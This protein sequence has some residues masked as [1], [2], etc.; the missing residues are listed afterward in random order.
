MFNK[1]KPCV[2]NTPIIQNSLQNPPINNINNTEN[3]DYNCKY[4]QKKF[5]RSDNLKRHLDG[6]CKVKTSCNELE[7]FKNEFENMKNEIIELKKQLNI[8]NDIEKTQYVI[9]ATNIGQVVNN[10]TINNTVNLNIQIVQYGKEDISKLELYDAI[11]VYLKSSGKTIFSNMLKH[12]NFNEKY[13]QN[14]N[15]YISDLARQIV[16]YHNGTRWCYKKFNNI[17]I[18]I[19]NNLVAHIKTFVDKFESN[20]KN[21]K[22]SVTDKLKINK[23]ILKLALND[24]PDYDSQVSDTD[25]N[26]E[27]GPNIKLKKRQEEVQEMIFDEL[28]ET[29]HNNKTSVVKV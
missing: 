3:N 29:L 24:D 6:R 10:N 8:K 4:C 1:K 28:Q 14:H 17:K 7:K 20:T 5:T 21:I 15:I 11:N 13:P 12:I 25:S 9:P 22:K 26:S 18:D 19:I 2:Q 27:Y 23:R 16:K